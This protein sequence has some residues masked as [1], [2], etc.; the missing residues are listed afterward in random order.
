MNKEQLLQRRNELE[1][2]FE[3]TQK[4]RDSLT[5]ELLRMQGKFNLINELLVEIEST[6]YPASEPDKETKE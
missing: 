5:E 2:G 1:A 6:S 4:Q 3:V